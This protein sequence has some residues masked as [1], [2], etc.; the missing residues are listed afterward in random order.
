MPVHDFLRIHRR[1]LLRAGG[2]LILGTALSGTRALAQTKLK[3]GVIGSG[4]IGGTI[5]TLWVK[6]G[7]PVLF[8]SRHPEELKDLVAGLGELAKP[9][10]VE[11]AI[12][13][14]A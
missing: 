13:F 11:E 9:G 3:I 5:G 7:H 1:A 10:T 2:T 14:G 8:S 12:A 4:H 6:S